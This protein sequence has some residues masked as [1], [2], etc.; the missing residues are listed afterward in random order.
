MLEEELTARPFLQPILSTSR[1]GGLIDGEFERLRPCRELKPNDVEFEREPASS[2][3]VVVRIPSPLIWW[4]TAQLAALS[5]CQAT[6]LL[7]AICF[8]EGTH[9]YG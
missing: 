3:Y 4:Q 1:S 2:Q 8:G 6:I 5:R 7:Q 9:Q